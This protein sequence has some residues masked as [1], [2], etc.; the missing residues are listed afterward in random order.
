M[1]S[2]TDS[3][4]RELT[5]FLKVQDEIGGVIPSKLA[6]GTQLFIDTDKFLFQVTVDRS[7]GTPKF[8]VDSGA[9]LGDRVCVDIGSYHEPLK[10][11]RQDYIGLDMRLVLRFSNGSNI[12]SGVILGMSVKGEGYDYELWEKVKAKRRIEAEEA[13]RKAEEEKQSPPG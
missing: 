9:Q 6:H 11:D 7:N 10:Y 13:A 2:M 12:L 4:Q 3:Q 1:A 8:I 5:A